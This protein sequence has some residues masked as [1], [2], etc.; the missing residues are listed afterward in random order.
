MCEHVR[1]QNPQDVLGGM[2]VAINSFRQIFQLVA[3][4]Q[5]MMSHLMFTFTGLLF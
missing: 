1:K 2:P 4:E 3:T 5:S